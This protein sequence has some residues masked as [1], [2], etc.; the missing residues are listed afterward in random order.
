MALLRSSRVRTTAVITALLALVVVATGFTAATVTSSRPSTSAAARPAGGNVLASLPLAFEPAGPGGFVVHGPGYSVALGATDATLAVDGGVFG[1]RPAGAAAA[2]AAPL[3]GRDPL[4]GTVTRLRGDDAAAWNA[5]LP[6][7]GSVVARQVWPGVDMVWHGDRRRLEHD[8]VVA[9]GADPGAVALD[10]DGARSLSV[11]GGGDLVIDLGGTTT[12]MARPVVYQDAPGGRR[13]VSGSFELLGPTRIGFRVGTYDPTLPLV[14]DPTLL[15]STLLG[16]A[17]ADSGY[18]IATDREGNTYV[19]GSTE[20]ADF[21]T[22]T[23][24]QPKLALPS[25]VGGSASDVFVSKIN[26]AGTALVWSTYLGGGGRDTG[27]GVTVGADGGVYVTGVTESPDFPRAKAAQDRYGGG[28]SDAFVARISPNG[29]SLDWS[30]FVGGSGT[31]GARGVAVDSSGAVYV[32]GSTSSVDFPSIGA[33]QAGPFRPD[34]I[35]AFVVKIPATGAPLAFATRLGGSSDDH[36]LAI[37]V[38]AQG[39]AYVTGD[40][41]SSGFPIVRPFQAGAGGSANGVAGSFPD[42]F[43][44]K[45]SPTGSALVYSTFLGGSDVDQGTAIAVDAAGAAYVTGNT[46]SPNFPTVAAIQPRKDADS[47][48]FVAKLDPPGATLVYSTYYGGTGADGANAIAVDSTGSAVVVG[49]TGSTNWPTSRAMQPAKAGGSDAFVLKLNPAGISALF[50]SF[51]GGRDED[52]G[53]GVALDVQGTVHLLGT[54]ASNDFPAV[55]SL[56]PGRVATA[57]DAFVSTLSLTDATAPVA[58]TPVPASSTGHDRRVRALGILTLVLLLGAVA[59][60][61]YLRTRARTGTPAPGPVGPPRGRRPEAT[62]GLRVLPEDADATVAST[63]WTGAGVGAG[64][65]AGT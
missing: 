4:P 21:P 51:V 48:A 39:S 6:T 57:G 27:Y 33:Q 11:D 42:A 38:D 45:Y 50:S 19:V 34:D 5:G 17:G 8:M 16:G 1:L 56:Q 26:A 54:T 20:S 61:V 49:T 44:T 46:N 13:S 24:F 18:G 59:Q 35:D 7:Y 43:V 30:T 10:V 32:T 29:S 60:T 64:A 22:G 47:D 28:P 31:D 23:P 36:G 53:L 37:A 14:I 62:A 2:S 41:L 52:Q 65:R 63:P 25:A 9:P 15:T 12:R 55:K 3:V 40:T 58:A